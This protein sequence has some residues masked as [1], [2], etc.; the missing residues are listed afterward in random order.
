M[1]E[2]CL[3][4]PPCLFPAGEAHPPVWAAAAG[5]ADSLDRETGREPGKSV[6]DR[7]A[8]LLGLRMGRSWEGGS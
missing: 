5:A 8:G 7:I 1:G 6:E 3:G 2:R 4:P